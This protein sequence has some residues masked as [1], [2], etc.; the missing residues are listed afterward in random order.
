MSNTPHD[1]VTPATEKPED[2]AAPTAWEAALR[3]LV[4][5]RG[6]ALTVIAVAAGIA[7]ARYMQEVL[8]PFVLAG[9]VFYAL[10]PIVDRLKRWHVPRAIGAAAAIFLVVGATAGTVYSLYDEAVAVVEQLP[11]A[12][13]K[14]RRMLPATERGGESTLQKLQTAADEL[15]QTAAAATG[16]ASAPRGVTRVQ[17]EEPAFRASDYVWWSGMSA[18]SLLGQA[19]LVLFL[20]YFLLVYDDLFKRKLVEIIG[21]TLSRKKVTVQILNDIAAQIE[22]FMLVQIFTSVVV[23]VAT[24]VALWWVGL[25][26]PWVWGLAAGILNSVPYFGPLIVTIGLT[27]IAFL[28]FDAP[29]T[30]IGVGGIAMLITTIEGWWLTPML[31]GRVSE[32]NKIAMF[33]GLLFWSWLWGVPGMLLAIP[34]M[35][36]AKVVCE[37]VEDLQPI[38]KLLGE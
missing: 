1:D 21:P 11:E 6:V 30:A 25:E 37:R 27:T 17:I 22:R 18:I 28:Q 4:D 32:M 2:A 23:A 38:G 35:M 8:I 9:L 14:L 36:V 5:A 31:M 15:G 24:G 10:D 12:A 29:S 20:T 33:A 34:M 26:Q 13:R 16:G 19:A 7:L 3:P